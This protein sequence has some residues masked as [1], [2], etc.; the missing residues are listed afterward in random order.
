MSLESHIPNW[1]QAAP[2][3]CWW[4]PAP[5]GKMQQ[6][7]AGETVPLQE[8]L[9]SDLVQVEVPG[10]KLLWWVFDSRTVFW[11]LSSVLP[12]FPPWAMSQGIRHINQQ[13]VCF[14]TGCV[15]CAVVISETRSPCGRLLCWRWRA[16]ISSCAFWGWGNTLHEFPEHQ[17]QGE[18]SATA[19][20]E[21]LALPQLCIW[22]CSRCEIGR[23][24]YLWLCS[25]NCWAFQWSY[26]YSE[27]RTGKCC[28]FE[29]AVYLVKGLLWS[30]GM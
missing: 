25:Q 13:T 19:S 10:H 17:T 6:Q 14:S 11:I 16:L 1:R 9:S 28:C 30:S 29:G 4:N 26:P 20:K 12:S 24:S 2:C 15:N 3:D 5:G 21:K 18:H 7:P 23:T 8:L 22:T 27:T